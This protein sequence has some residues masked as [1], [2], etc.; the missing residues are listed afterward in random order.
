MSAAMGLQPGMR[1][2]NDMVLSR[3]WLPFAVWLVVSICTFGLGWLIVSGHFFKFVINETYIVDAKGERLG[4]LACNYDVEDSMGQV[5]LWLVA[6]I[7]TLGVALLFYSFYAARAA[8]N[9]TE[10]EWF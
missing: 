6:S 3:A 8:L 7:V 9:A 10:I 4:R 2:K 5:G 1:L